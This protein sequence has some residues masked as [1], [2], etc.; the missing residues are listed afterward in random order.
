MEP[1][2][3]YKLQSMGLIKI[4]GNTVEPRCNL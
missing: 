4:L 2:L 3:A 1:V